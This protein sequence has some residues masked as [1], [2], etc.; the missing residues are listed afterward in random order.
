[1]AVV[2]ARETPAEAVRAVL[3]REAGER[4]RSVRLFDVY[5]GPPLPEDQVSLTFSL[6]L[7]AEDRTLTDTEALQL[8]DRLRGALKREC[9][10]EFR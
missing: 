3:L 8:L 5:T 1:L 9:Q 4:A 6:V 7:G 10:A 2:V